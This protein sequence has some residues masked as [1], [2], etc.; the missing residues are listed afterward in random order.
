MSCLLSSFLAKSKYT[1]QTIRTHVYL[2]KNKEGTD[3]HRITCSNI[4]FSTISNF[5]LY[6]S[7]D[8]YSHNSHKQRHPIAIGTVSIKS[9]IICRVYLNPHNL[10]HHCLIAISTQKTCF[11]NKYNGRGSYIILFIH[12]VL[13]VLQLSLYTSIARESCNSVF[14]IKLSGFLNCDFPILRREVGDRVEL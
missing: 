2:G 1:N 4:S 6:S 11:S 7:R 9:R 14:P 8:R 3:Y 12:S 13:H 5:I 10:L